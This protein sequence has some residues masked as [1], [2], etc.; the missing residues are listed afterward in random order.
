MLNADGIVMFCMACVATI[1][2]NIGARYKGISHKWSHL[3]RKL[4]AGMSVHKCQFDQ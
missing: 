3:R 4:R 2:W 1:D